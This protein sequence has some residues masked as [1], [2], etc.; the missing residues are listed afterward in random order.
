MPNINPRIRSL[1][2]LLGVARKV[3]NTAAAEDK[4]AQP[5]NNGFQILS[6][7]AIRG[8]RGHPF[9]LYEGDRLNDLVESISEHGVLTPA[10]I[11]KIERDE[12]GFE[13]EMLAGH[14]RQN[15]A[16]IANREL[17]CIVK[18][19]L[20]D[21]DAWIYV[22]ETNVL[23]RSFSEMLPSEK[24]AVL[25]LR[26]SKMICQGRR[27]D[28]IEELKKLEN[29][30]EIR[31]NKTCGIDCHKSKSRD[32]VGAEYNLKGRAVANYLRINELSVAL[33][34]RIDDGEFTIAAAVQLSY[35]AQEEQQMVE[36]VLSE[37]EY[38]VNEGKAVLLREYTGKLTPERAEQILSGEFS[39]KPKKS[40]AAA[41]KVK[42]AIYKKY[43]TASI[44]QKEF[45]SIV[46]EALALYFAQK[47]AA[48]V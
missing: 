24:A 12:D 15:A 36:A 44:T 31:E 17:P 40:T 20:S 41:F 16:A 14:N 42:P 21:E 18:E 11:R 27:N 13:Y 5:A 46:D 22:I 1:D 47:E 10:I 9:R 38:K 43:F 32:V 37:S 35:L 4:P 26:Y 33:K 39:R 28:I 30:D 45:D 7:E 6:P 29:P 2:D 8:F 23:Q 34:I 25:A 3:E 19:N 48:A